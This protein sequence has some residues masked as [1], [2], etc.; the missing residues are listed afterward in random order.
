MGDHPTMAVGY[1]PTADLILAQYPLPSGL[2]NL[3]YL[4]S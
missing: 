3:G 4:I 1:S 2:K